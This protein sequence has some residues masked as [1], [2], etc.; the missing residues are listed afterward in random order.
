MTLTKQD[1]IENV[2]YR[3]DYPQKKAVHVTETLLEIIK[4]TLGNGERVLVSGFGSFEVNDKKARKGRNPA[5]G[6]TMILEQRR[7]VTFKCSNNL[8]KKVNL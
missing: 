3:L 7:V 5:T 1:I 2:S 6:D 8:R 4:K